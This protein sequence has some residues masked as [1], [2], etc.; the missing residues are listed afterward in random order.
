MER[1]SDRDQDRETSHEPTGRDEGIEPGRAWLAVIVDAGLLGLFAIQHSV[2]A[3]PRFKRWWTRFVPDAIERSTFILATSLVLALMMWQWRPLPDMVWSVSTGWIR[4]VVWLLYGAGWAIVLT[5]TFLIGHFDFVGLR[6][7]LA[8]ARRERYTEPG[9]RQPLL[10]RL[11]RHP[12]M[13]GFLI[14]FWVVPD[15][16]VGR[17][18]FAGAATGYILIGV[19][20]EERDLRRDLGEPYAL[21]AEEVPRFVP[22]LT[23]GRPAT[24]STTHAE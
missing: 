21:Y 16:S 3:R 14:A 17:L 20:F 15:M 7:A 11:I 8:R 23:R 6:Q 22:R 4:V 18:L 24:D 2:M 13:T 12:I 9:F 1:R 19:R 10:Y 5:S